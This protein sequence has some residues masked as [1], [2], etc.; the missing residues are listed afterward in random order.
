MGGTNKGNVIEHLTNWATAAS[1]EKHQISNIWTDT[2]L[3]QSN[4]KSLK[5]ESP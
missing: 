4:F 2:L 5:I 3:V 1:K